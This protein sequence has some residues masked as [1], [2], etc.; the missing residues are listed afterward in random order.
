MHSVCTVT[1]WQKKIKIGTKIA[2][3][4]EPGL[5]SCEQAT[6]RLRILCQPLS[7]QY[8]LPRRK[9]LH[10]PCFHMQ[11]GCVCIFSLLR[12]EALLSTQARHLVCC[13]VLLRITSQLQMQPRLQPAALQ[14]MCKVCSRESSHADLVFK[15]FFLRNSTPYCFCVHRKTRDMRGEASARHA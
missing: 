13:T 11:L 4:L 12:E 3:E 5:D 10:H 14:F 15:D 8:P 7:T 1:R 6:A 9:H 2:A